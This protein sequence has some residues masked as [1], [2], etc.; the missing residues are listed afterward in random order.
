MHKNYRVIFSDQTKNEVS[1]ISRVTYLELI[2]KKVFGGKKRDVKILRA[3]SQGDQIASFK[4][5][6]TSEEGTKLVSYYSLVLENKHWKVVQDL[7]Y[8]EAK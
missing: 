5:T 2:E 1:E 4:V 8:M 7:V 3:E 6:T